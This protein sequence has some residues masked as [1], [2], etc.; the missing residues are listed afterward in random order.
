MI[1]PILADLIVVIHFIWILFMLAGFL[2]TLYAFRRK[3]IFDWWVFRTLHLLGIAYVGLLTVLRQHCPLTVL[4]YSLR[5]RHDPG[6]TYPGS[7]IIY[8]VEKLVY[9]GVNPLSIFIPTVMI[10]VFTIVVF[11]VRPP[12]RIKGYF[13]KG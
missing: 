13:N 11:I 9:P 1:Y 12:A 3:A 5:T 8:Y 10:A 4:E 6:L 2:L 7:F